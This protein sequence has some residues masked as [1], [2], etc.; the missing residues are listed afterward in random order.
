[1]KRLVGVTAFLALLGGALMVHEEEPGLTVL[2]GALLV[3]ATAP[4]MFAVVILADPRARLWLRERS[5]YVSM[6]VSLF[7]VI[8]LA[9]AGA[10]HGQFDPYG[11]IVVGVGSGAALLALDEIAPGRP[12]LGSIDL[13]VWL[14]LWV[15][16]NS[17]W[18]CLWLR[19]LLGHV[20]FE[21]LAL[22]VTLL[23]LVGWGAARDLPSLGY[24]PPSARDLAVGSAAFV[25][26]AVIAI[27]VG[28]LLGFLEWQ[29]ARSF[30]PSQVVLDTI[31]IG[32]MV[33]VPEELFFR[34]ILDGGLT[35]TLDRPWLS[36]LISSTAFGLMHW[37]RRDVLVERIEYC[38]LATVAGVFYGLA[39]RRGGGLPSAVITH[40][41]VDVLWKTF[42][43]RPGH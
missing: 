30:Q 22:A 31:G 32:L 28:C 7:L 43:E 14:F 36:L 39:Y 5:R 40:T 23:A 34:G 13:L 11:L 6:G 19:P 10:A 42:F 25:P 15:P 3:L 4:L 41:L 33:A 12:S 20:A 26:F 21:W 17:R 8:E 1:M 24:R 38:S 18:T 9:L 27:P 35:R 29:G 37:V 16:F 2:P